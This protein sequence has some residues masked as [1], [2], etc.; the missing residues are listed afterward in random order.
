MRREILIAAIIATCM[1]VA[2]AQRAPAS[3]ANVSHADL[4]VGYQYIGAN[5]P[6][7]A[8]DHF[9]LQ[10]GYV[11]GSY[12]LNSW[13]SIAGEFSGEHASK[14]SQLG[15]DV[16]LMTFTGGPR[17]TRNY[18]RFTPFAEALF[19]GA[20]AGNS[21]FPQGSTGSSSSATSWAMQLGGGLDFRL[22]DRWAIRVPT[23]H[24]LRTAFPNGSTDDQN[25][26]MI[27]GGVVFHFG[28]Y[29]K[30]EPVAYAAPA[31][32]LSFNCTSD[33]AGIVQGQALNITG[34]TLTEPGGAAVNYTWTTTGGTVQGSGRQ[35]SISTVGLAP[36]DYHVTGHAALV[37]HPSSDTSC[38][39]TFHV[40]APESPAPVV[41]QQPSDTQEDR[42]FHENVPDALFD[43]D[44]YSIRP[45]AQAAIDKA[46]QYLQSNP[47]IS[48]LIAGYA[49]ERGS[50]EYNLALAEKRANA[51][52]NALIQ[53][54]ISGERLQIISYGK[55]AQVCTAR[56]EACYQQNRRAAFNMRH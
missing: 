26:L 49:D 12:V 21:Y 34:N 31:P 52:R 30:R 20:H 14:I 25:Q 39:L 35:V 5:A 54:G 33:Y 38:N 11:S 19:G 45:D 4:S 2:F 37:S 1:P 44:S 3:A 8:S 24:Y 28:S 9:S 46:T 16:T 36:G 7:G 50:N 43:Y 53:G 10:G 40:L 22:N 6:P 13:I 23:V 18:G 47:Q 51:A 32:Q 15:Q 42:V 41:E 29:A 55:E 48:V 27:G 17:I 56:T